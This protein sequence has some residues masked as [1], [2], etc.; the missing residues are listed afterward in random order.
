MII[1]GHRI[2]LLGILF[3]FKGLRLF[4]DCFRIVHGRAD[5]F[6]THF[7]SSL[8]YIEYVALSWLCELAV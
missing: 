7:A 4:I 2:E 3:C 5:D 6:H 1:R 8:H